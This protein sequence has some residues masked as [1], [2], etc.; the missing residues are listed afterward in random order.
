MLTNTLLMGLDITWFGGAKSNPDSKFDC[1]AALYFDAEGQAVLSMKRVALADKDKALDRDPG[2]TKILSAVD[3]MLAK[4]CDPNTKVIFA[5]D[6]PI[7][8]A[9]RAHLPAHRQP[10][11]ATGTAERRAAENKLNDAVKAHPEVEYKWRPPILPGAPLAARVVNFTNGLVQRGFKLWT[12]GMEEAQRLAIEVYPK[13]AIWAAKAQGGFGASATPAEVTAYKS[14]DIKDEVLTQER[15]DEL[16]TTTL[17]GFS[18]LTGA[19]GIWRGSI[20]NALGWLFRDQSWGGEI[21]GG[22]LLDD[23]VD[24]MICLA[25]ALSF[26][27]GKAHVWFDEAHT[28]DGHIFGAG[29]AA[30]PFQGTIPASSASAVAATPARPITPEP[31]F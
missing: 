3:E 9:T 26:A 22:K 5:I 10:V 27:N 4:Y 18:D 11:S 15:A 6:A 23:A 29:N 12:P 28:D 2:A 8:A 25:V 30:P 24:T 13:E 19:P 17:S 1:L 14:K 16:V 31:I 20:K 7:Q 21:H